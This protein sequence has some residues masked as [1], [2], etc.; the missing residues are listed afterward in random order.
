MRGVTIRDIGEQAG[1]PA[2]GTIYSWIARDEGGFHA[3]YTAAK[4]VQAELM[5][6]EM[7]AIADRTRTGIK[8]RETKDGT[9]RET[10]DMVERAR[11][12]VDTP[13]SGCCRASC[14]PKKWGD[15]V[16][17]EASGPDG[18]PIQVK[19]ENAPRSRL[20][21]LDAVLAKLAK[22]AGGDCE[23]AQS[24]NSGDAAPKPELSSRRWPR[25][26]CSSARFAADRRSV[27]RR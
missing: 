13:A 27:G 26:S 17:L 10:G 5:A 15:K 11:L 3:R 18:G 14:M 22:L 21:A 9:F 6:E 7:L 19:N 8:V 25:R 16:Q 2:A 1:M 23:I 12:Q 20:P 24:G 4:A